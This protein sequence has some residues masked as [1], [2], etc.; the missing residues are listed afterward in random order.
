MRL[1]VLCTVGVLVLSVALSGCVTTDAR[2]EIVSPE[3]SPPKEPGERRLEDVPIRAAWTPEER[4]LPIVLAGLPAAVPESHILRELPVVG[5]QGSQASGTAWAVGYVAM[6]VLVRKRGVR[7]YVCSPAFVHNQLQRDEN[8]VEIREAAHLLA[9]TGCA[10]F[11]SMPYNADDALTR[12]SPSALNR[13][14]E[15]RARGFGRVDYTDLNQMR[16]HL[17]QGSVIIATIAVTKNFL[18][19]DKAN[20][21][22]PKGFFVGR[23]TV[24]IVGYD[25]RTRE[26]LIQNSAGIEWGGQGLARIPYSWMVRIIGNAY[27]LW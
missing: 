16:A 21:P 10:P 13:A 14:R 7:D 12:P 25:D 18:E 5:N 24:A 20:W 2:G 17:L 26:F 3:A 23:H 6:S 1:S 22:G 8:G 19:L 15:F 9:T 11:E 27:V 4:R